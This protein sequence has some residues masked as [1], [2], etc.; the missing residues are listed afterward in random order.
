MNRR[1]K[2]GLE[3]VLVRSLATGLN[4]EDRPLG[5]R[6]SQPGATWSL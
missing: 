4:I 3:N 1:L 5:G 6:M 2:E